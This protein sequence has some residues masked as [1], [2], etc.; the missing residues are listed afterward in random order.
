MNRRSFLKSLAPMAAAARGGLARQRRP[1]IVLIVADD[2]G[3]GDLG[4][5]G[6][7]RIRTP[8]IDRMAAEGTRFT[9]FYAGSTVCAPSRS[10]LMTGTHTG[11][12]LVR[13][14]FSPTSGRV[15]LRPEDTT[16]AEVLKG[17]G[18]R[19]AAFGK[20][21][22]GEASTTGTPNNKGFDEWFGYLNQR[23][24]H[25]YYPEH[26]W[27]NGREVFLRGN[28]GGYRTEF[29]H[30]LFAERALEFIGANRDEPFFLYLP[31]TI[32]H[33][34]NELAA[35]TG[36]GF[37]VPDYGPYAT[38]GWPAPETGYAAM[39]TRMDRDVGRILRLL[40]DRGIAE[41]TLVLF[42]SDNGP[43]SVGGHDREFFGSRG[44][45]RGGKRD[46]Y[47]GGI[48]VPLVAWQPGRV[49]AGA[50]SDQVWSFWDFPATAAE[51]AGVEPPE[52]ADGVSA[53]PALFGEQAPPRPPLYWEFHEGGFHQA[54]LD[55]DWK[56]VRHGLDAP[57]ELYDLAEDPVEERNVAESH[58]EAVRRMKRLFETSHTP[59]V[60]YR[61][62]GE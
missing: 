53:A 14:N 6:Q 32:P 25:N 2:L 46:L 39:I 38:K 11:H 3:Y 23:H 20:W 62:E 56:A 18:Y 49:K 34:D 19:T 59:S 16:V 24:A 12:T 36:D 9:R 45:L 55:G 48:R 41:D 26:L 37:P 13:G 8:E 57:I 43:V 21:G 33:T 31:F 29:T 17:A 7:K 51:L 47:E 52:G 54:I 40:E 58:A 44:G 35:A 4:C 28:M 27:E 30:D 10:C 60:E 22:L 61:V 1:N 50:V 42:T 5:Y 15:S